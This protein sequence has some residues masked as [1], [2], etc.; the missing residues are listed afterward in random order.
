MDLDIIL[1]LT[2]KIKGTT[3]ATL[4][5]LCETKN[6]MEEITGERVIIFRTTEGTSG[7]EAQVRRRLEAAG[8]NPLLF[9]AG[10]LPWGERLG[11]LPVI[12]HKGKY[13]LQCVILSPG[14]SVYFLPSSKKEVNPAD[15]GIRPRFQ[16]LNQG[17]APEDQ[18]HVR[19][20]NIDHITRLVIL[21]EEIFPMTG[22]SESS[23]I[24]PF[25]I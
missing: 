8:K 25:K 22:N 23:T 24:T 14:K 9:R 21:G 7:Y 4:D 16:N 19:T 3:F 18:V 15:F 10:P 11:D 6:V 12:S 13:Y 17:L 20:Y 2:E 5:A 1:Q